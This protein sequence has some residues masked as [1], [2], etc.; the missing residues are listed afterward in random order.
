MTIERKMIH[1]SV[2]VR[3]KD[4]EVTVV[5]L[6]DDGTSW[7]LRG[8]PDA[9]IGWDRNWSLLPEIPQKIIKR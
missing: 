8:Y 2:D 9:P 1:V 6:C 3:D 5:A 7:M 4:R